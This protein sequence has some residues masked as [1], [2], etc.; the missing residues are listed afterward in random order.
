MAVFFALCTVET[1]LCY[2]IDFYLSGFDLGYIQN[3]VDQCKQQLTCS[4]D[5][6]CVLRY[7]LWDIPPQDDLIHD[8]DKG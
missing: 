5:I 7:V 8:M 1:L 6:P 2:G 3:I 4:L